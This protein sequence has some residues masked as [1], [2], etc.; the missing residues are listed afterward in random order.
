VREPI[1]HDGTV[2]DPAQGSLANAN[3]APPSSAS[4]GCGSPCVR[5]LLSPPSGR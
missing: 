2:T 1:A 3:A 5:Q 4:I